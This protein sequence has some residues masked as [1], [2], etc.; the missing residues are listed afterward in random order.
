M[1]VILKLRGYLSVMI[2][3]LRSAFYDVLQ[4]PCQKTKMLWITK[5]LRLVSIKNQ[6]VSRWKPIEK[7]GVSWR[8]FQAGLDWMYE[9][10][11]R[12]SE[13]KHLTT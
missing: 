11:P 7:A 10:R 8:P 6:M 13:K 4:N 2:S 3:F 1:V 12:Y 9:I 5:T